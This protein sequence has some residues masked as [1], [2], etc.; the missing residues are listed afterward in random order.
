MGMEDLT[1]KRCAPCEGGMPK[2][3]EKRI[4]ELVPQVPGW[5]VVD[6]KLHR[7][8]RFPDFATAIR[9]V[10]RMAQ[11]AESEQHHPNFCVDYGRV[12]VRIWTHAIGGLSENDF[13][14]AA[15]LDATLD[16]RG[17]PCGHP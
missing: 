8:F 6:G 1:R 9:F 2:V 12:E 5:S 16:E 13:I 7:R 14:L 3:D 17:L 4:A 15:K 11:I 10:D